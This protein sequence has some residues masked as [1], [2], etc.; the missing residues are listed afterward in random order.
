MAWPRLK[1]RWIFY[2]TQSLHKVGTARMKPATRRRLHKTGRLARWHSFKS[3]SVLGMRVWY[4]YEHRPRVR[5]ERVVYEFPYGLF[6]D[7][8][9]RIHN[10]DAIAKV[11]DRRQVVGDVNHSQIMSPL[12][13]AE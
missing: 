5:M 9:C 11:P 1:F 3:S 2:F 8:L 13:A 12:Q 10:E 4:R 7:D 6:L